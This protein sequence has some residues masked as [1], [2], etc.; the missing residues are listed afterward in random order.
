[1][2]SDIQI[3]KPENQHFDGWKRMFEGYNEFYNVSFTEEKAQRL[4]SWLLDPSHPC[5]ALIAVNHQQDVIGL[6]HFREM[7]RPLHAAVA[8]FLDDL[9]VSPQ[10]RKHHV[11]QR[12]IDQV[13]EIG[14]QRNWTVIRWLTAD[15]NYRARGLYDQCAVRTG[16]LTYEIKL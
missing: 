13:S 9:Y 3:I 8:G 14:R 4:W 7:P 2:S 11:G 16:W 15:N 10:F 12:L 5:E 6:A 1:M